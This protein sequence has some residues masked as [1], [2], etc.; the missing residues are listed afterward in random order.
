MRILYFLAGVLLVFLVSCNRSAK[1]KLS[2]DLNS[3]TEQAL[4]YSDGQ[5]YTTDDLFIGTATEIKVHPEGFIVIHDVKTEDQIQI[6]DLQNGSTELF[7]KRGQGPLEL[8]SVRDVA[9]YNDD[10]WVSGMH[11]GRVIRLS[12]NRDL[13]KFEASEAFNLSKSNFFRALP[14]ADNRFLI[15]SK[16]TSGKRMEIVDNQG[17]I[18]REAGSFPEVPIQENFRLNN[19]F[20][21]SEVAVAP[22][23]EHVAVVCKS[24]DYIDIYT[25]ETWELKKRLRGPL[26]AEVEFAEIETP[27]GHKL[28]GQKPRFFIYDTAASNNDMFFVSY[29]GIEAKQG[30]DFE[31]YP[32]QIFSFDWN[33]QPLKCYHFDFPV[34]CFDVDW[35]NKKL[36]CI[37]ENPESEIV[38]FNI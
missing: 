6:I 10:V 32:Q 20:L 25:T 35:N 17:G 1:D 4:H 37:T 23:R 22:N 15:L 28:F 12:F 14:L 11:E 33:G 24:I 2:F 38:I 31:K 16:A 18:L 8:V 21:Q 34:H 30:K 5:K 26:G 9:I 3:F 13:R 29:L 19:A 27:E 36:Y 7:I